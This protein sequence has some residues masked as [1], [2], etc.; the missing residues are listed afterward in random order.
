MSLL[1]KVFS[2]D[3]DARENSRSGAVIHE[4]HH[5][6]ARQALI[7]AGFRALGLRANAHF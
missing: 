6:A 3:F 2:P 5:G 1:G 4:P 7:W